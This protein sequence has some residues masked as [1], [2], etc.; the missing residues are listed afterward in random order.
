[1]GANRIGGLAKASSC[2]L[3]D[4]GL[5]GNTASVPVSFAGE[6]RLAMGSSDGKSDKGGWYRDE[7]RHLGTSVGDALK[8][9][10]NFPLY[11]CGCDMAL[12]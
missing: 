3:A 12:R 11:D 8:H 4:M 6:G 2:E 5:Y 9:R 1:V 10:L 7:R